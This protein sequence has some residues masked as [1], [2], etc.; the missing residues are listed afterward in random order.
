MACGTSMRNGWI[1]CRVVMPFTATDRFGQHSVRDCWQTSKNVG[2]LGALL[3]LLSLLQ[4]RRTGPAR[5]GRPAR[6]QRPDGP[7]RRRAAAHLGYPVHADPGDA[8]RLPARRR[9]GAAAAAARRRR[10][11]RGRGRACA[12]PPVTSPASRRR[13]YGRWSSSSRCCRPGCGT[14]STPCTPYTVQITRPRTGR[15]PDD[16]DRD[17]RRL[18]RPPAAAVRLPRTT[19]APSSVRTRR[20]APPGPHRPPVVPGR[21]GRRPRRLADLPGGPDRAAHA[22][23]TAVRPRASHP[24][25]PPPSW[26]EASTPR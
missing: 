24:P 10:G 23:R 1:S 2:D 3:R 4:T 25:T 7:P 26:S 13:P 20:A 12:P 22:N 6:R 21:L 8:G 9:R 11:G 15:R 18:P 19:T 16:A 17:R 14:G 5:A